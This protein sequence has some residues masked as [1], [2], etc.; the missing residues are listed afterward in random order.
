LYFSPLELQWLQNS[1][2]VTST[3]LRLSTLEKHYHSIFDPLFQSFQHSRGKRVDDEDSD[4]DESDDDFEEFTEFDPKL[5]TLDEWKWALSMVWART[6]VV[7]EEGARLDSIERQQQRKE[8]TSN[9]FGLDESDEDS[10]LGMGALVPGADFFNAPPLLKDKQEVAKINTNDNNIAI[11]QE[12][13]RFVQHPQVGVKA[14]TSSGQLV[15]YALQPCSPGQ[16]IFMEYGKYKEHS[17]QELLLDY[18]FIRTDNID[19]IF[20]LPPSQL[21]QLF[22]SSHSP[23]PPPSSSS[24]S[25]SSSTSLPASYVIQQKKKKLLQKHRF[26]QEYYI[27][28]ADQFPGQLVWALR[29]ALMTSKETQEFKDLAVSA[30]EDPVFGGPGSKSMSISPPPI[31][32]DNERLAIRSAIRHLERVSNSYASTLQVDE[33][34]LKGHKYESMNEFHALMVRVSEKKALRD[35][36]QRLQFYLHHFSQQQPQNKGNQDLPLAD[37]DSKI[38]LQQDYIL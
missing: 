18:G 35:T 31:S 4:E 27:I 20:V 37:Y 23:P 17:N 34:L 9:N 3:Q 16:Q 19:T 38:P 5:F 21:L 10:N 11:D 32:E 13:A 30:Y 1:S 24:S 2:L 28:R 15:Y 29:L 14:G 33:Q 6:F 26:W 12:T 8:K 36:V 7:P 22:Q 25:S